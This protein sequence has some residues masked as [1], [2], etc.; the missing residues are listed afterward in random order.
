MSNATSSPSSSS[1]VAVFAKKVTTILQLSM[2][3]FVGMAILPFSK[4]MFK[5]L[6]MIT[7]DTKKDSKEGEETMTPESFHSIITSRRT[8][9]KFGPTLPDNWEVKVERAIRAAITAPNHKK[10]EPWRFHLLGPNTIRQICNLQQSLLLEAKAER[11]GVSINDI[12]VDEAIE[13]KVNRWLG[14]KGWLIVTCQQYKEK[15]DESVTTSTAATGETANHQHSTTTMEKPNG[16]AREDYAACC[17]AVQNLC[18]QFHAD[19]IGTKWTTGKINFDTRF[20]EAAGLPSLE[21]VYVVG[22]IWFGI[23]EKAPKKRHLKLS[24]DDVLQRHE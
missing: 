6:G 17:C 4:F 19:G 16:R 5:S 14:V 2:T 8:T 24:L 18:L 23:S 12:T 15:G 21:D 1:T 11:E 20:H 7:D 10:T 13:K 9:A 22:T 3:I